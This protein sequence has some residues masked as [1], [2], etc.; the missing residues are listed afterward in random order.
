MMKKNED[1]IDQE[2]VVKPIKDNA[3][4]EKQQEADQTPQQ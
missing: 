2:K 4:V 1:S 3:K